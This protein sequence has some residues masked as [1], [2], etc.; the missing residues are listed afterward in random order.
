MAKIKERVLVEDPNLRAMFISR[1]GKLVVRAWL[2]VNS[3]GFDIEGYVRVAS[4]TEARRL[5]ED[6]M[7][8]SI[9]IMKNFA[10]GALGHAPASDSSQAF[11]DNLMCT[12][13]YSEV[14]TELLDQY[15]CAFEPL[16]AWAD[17][18]S[19]LSGSTSHAVHTASGVAARSAAL[20]LLPLLKPAMMIVFKDRYL[21][22]N[23]CRALPTYSNAALRLVSAFMRT[24]LTDLSPTA[25]LLTLLDSAET[26]SGSGQSI[27]GSGADD[28]SGCTLAGHL[29]VPLLPYITEYVENFLVNILAHGATS[30][31]TNGSQTS[32]SLMACEVAAVIKD[33]ICLTQHK[34]MA[35]LRHK[36][37]AQVCSC[38]LRFCWLLAF[39]FSRY[40]SAPHVD[41]CGFLGLIQAMRTYI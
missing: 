6:F 16:D 39:V 38:Y 41:V 14:L 27:F 4:R 31:G 22:I 11:P 7:D 1:L 34:A 5:V 13:A 32:G 23:R 30:G 29:A 8:A 2:V 24:L 35:S 21:L 26:D 10:S 15:N 18:L 40:R 37:S 9:E 25:S 36:V 20:S 17:A 19:G 33:I 28:I 3:E 12:S